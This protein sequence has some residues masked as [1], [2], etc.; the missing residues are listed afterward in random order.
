MYGKKLLRF[1]KFAD[2]VGSVESDKDL[3]SDIS[4]ENCACEIYKYRTRGLGWQQ[5]CHQGITCPSRRWQVHQVYNRCRGWV[6]K[7]NVI[8]WQ[9]LCCIS[10]QKCSYCYMYFG[11]VQSINYKKLVC[12]LRSATLSIHAPITTCTYKYTNLTMQS[13]IQSHVIYLCS[14]CHAPMINLRGKISTCPIFVR[15]FNPTFS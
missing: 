4:E 15:L 2:A 9:A 7:D 14:I 13:W 11:S 12:H 3:L 1:K 8:Q 10:I 6:V 5:G